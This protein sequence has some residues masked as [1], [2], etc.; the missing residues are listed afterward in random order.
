MPQSE[1]WPF[2][3]IFVDHLF[4][5]TTRV[6]WSI[7]TGFNDPA[8]HTFQ[9]QAGY[10][11]NGNAL[12]WVD[13][14]T[15]ANNVYYLSDDTGREQTGKRLLTHYRVVLTTPR[16][17]YVSGPQGI[18][19]ALTERDWLMAREIL[20]KERLRLG[21]V[22][23]T[24]YLLRRMRYG[25]Q[26]KANTDSLTGE[27]IDSGEPSSWGTAFKVGY[28]PPVGVQVDFN[29]TAIVERRGGADI[30]TNN[31]RPAEF[32]ARIVGFPDIAKE[33][34]WVDAVTDQRWCVGDIDVAASFR[35]VPLVYLV[36]FSLMPFSHVVYKIPVT[37]LSYD[38]TDTSQ[39]QPSVGTGCVRVDHDY[40][41][42][43]NLVYQTGDC[44]GIAGATILAFTKED[45][46]NANRVASA[47]VASSQTT[48]NGTWAWA[49][50]LNPGDYV[51][52]FQK[53]GEFG[54]D[55]VELTVTTPEPTTDDSLSVA[56]NSSSSVA[57]EFGDF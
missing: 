49:M 37:D 35:G 43:S 29:N 47:A 6:W 10:T 34:I 50:M 28:H 39:F 44:C 51:L 24:G 22:S 32:A 5:G 8:P 15:P 57:L 42:N 40:P 3:R 45:W 52:L 53:P 38:L 2:R 12:D 25:I 54:P 33:D 30:Q 9:L 16:A 7:D 1:S 18:T 13:I 27:I 48:T 26:N 56:V 41:D 31:S 4:R 20:R 55:T 17:S 21:L 11:G 46:D 14:G 19:G 23:Q 36:K